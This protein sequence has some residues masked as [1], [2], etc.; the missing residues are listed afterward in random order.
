MLASRQRRRLRDR[1]R[2]AVRLDRAQ[3]VASAVHRGGRLSLLRSLRD[4]VP[5]GR[6]AVRGCGGSHVPAA[7]RKPRARWIYR[8]VPAPSR[9]RREPRAADEPAARADLRKPRTPRGVEPWP[10]PPATSTTS[11][12]SARCRPTPTTASRRCARSRTSRSPGIRIGSYPDL[13][14]ALAMVKQAAARAN[15]ALGVLDAERADAIVARVPRDRGRRAPR[16][17]RGRH[18]PGRRRH[19]DQHERERGHRQP[20]ARAARAPAAATTSTCTP[21]TTSTSRSRPTT[22]TRRRSASRVC[23]AIARLLRRDGRAARRVRGQGDG[24]RRRR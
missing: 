21:T 2:A 14:R 23:F 1:R 4:H 13:V 11:S 6:P 3:R 18:D 8:V 15:R 22:S 19:V 10:A 20:R 12:A 7:R 24:V 9:D 16:A 5:Q 17:L